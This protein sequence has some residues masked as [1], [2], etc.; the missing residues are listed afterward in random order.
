MNHTE[1][2]AIT[3]HWL[4]IGGMLHKALL[5]LPEMLKGHAGA[6]VAFNIIESIRHMRACIAS[7]NH[8]ANDTMCMTIAEGVDT[9]RWDPEQRS[10][11]STGHIINLAI[12]AFFFT[13][14]QAFVDL[15]IQDAERLGRS[16]DDQ[17]VRSTEL[18]DHGNARTGWISQ[19]PVQKIH[20]FGVK[21]RTSHKLHRE[22]RALA[23]KGLYPPNDT[24]WFN[25]FDELCDAPDSWT[26]YITLIA[27]YP[28]KFGDYELA[29]NEWSLI[30]KTHDFLTEF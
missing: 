28:D 13:K 18:D 24:R 23:G 26:H 7:D 22:I 19:A 9:A 11:R 2:Q 16:V 30:D 4:D 20:A 1:L 3:G 14:D 5:A 17:L 15:A 21:L 10:R 27:R 6:Q 25:W 12:Q 29:L 8:A